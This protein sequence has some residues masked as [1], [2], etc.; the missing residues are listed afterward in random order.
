MGI[1]QVNKYGAITET[2]GL[3][4]LPNLPNTSFMKPMYLKMKDS[5]L[6]EPYRQHIWTYACINAKATA[7]K[8]VPFIIV[9][10]DKSGKTASKS[11]LNKIR[12]VPVER[13]HKHGI[14]YLV[15][16]GFEVIED[17]D[18][19]NLFNDP[20]PLM[21][22]AQLWE[23]YIV[24][25]HMTGEVFWT[26]GG[27]NGKVNETELPREIGPYPKQAFEP[28]VDK[29]TG[30]LTGWKKR[31]LGSKQTEEYERHQI[32]RFYRYNPY[33]VRGLAP[34][35]VVEK[36]ASQDLKAMVLNEALFDNGG[37]P[38]GFLKVLE[39]LGKDQKDKLI[40][41]FE[42]RHKGPENSG[43][44]GLL[45][46][47]AEF[48]FNP[49][50]Q[51]DMQYTDGRK[52]NRDETH[53]GLGVPKIKNSI[54]EDINFA[55]ALQ[56]D[57][58]FWQDQ[59]IPEA[60][61]IEDVVNQKLFNGRIKETQ[62]LYCLFDFS[63]VGALQSN[64][65]QNSD[66]AKRY[67][68]MG[69][70][71]NAINE[72]L[73][74]GFDKTEW[75]DTGYLPMN[76]VPA[77]QAG[78]PIETPENDESKSEIRHMVTKSARKE[79][80]TRLW[81]ARVF[82]PIE[83]A[84]QSKIKKYWYDL[85]V[86]QLKLFDDATKSLVKAI[87]TYAELDAILF[88]NE[89]WKAKL[90]QIAYPYLQNSA[91]YSIEDIT[92]LLGV[93]VWNVTDPRILAILNRKA[94]KIVGITDRCWSSLKNNL[95]AG[96]REGETVTE[97]STRIRNE[98]NQR[99]TPARTLTIAR[100]E[101]AQIASPVRHTVL[102]GEGVKTSDWSSSG[103][104]HVRG[105]HEILDGVGPV[106]IDHNY[107]VNLNRMAETLMYPSDPAGPAD[108]VINCRCAEIPAE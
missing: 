96:I 106:K 9:R 75:G 70:S 25:M 87:P 12:S 23:S 72:R 19:Y 3:E 20:N 107:M 5:E 53:A 64:V 74:L 37:M 34:F 15:K 71:A 27:K 40:N 22:R 2:K 18:V 81:I 95:A 86:E 16:S 48:I 54:Y 84:F 88:N 103:D 68:D 41:G 91:K 82:T 6:T 26:L 29:E 28:I 65:M 76:L 43:K 44:V 102:V 99:A 46:G 100:T 42:A 7:L 21:C 66:V 39:F 90:K 62:G 31:K 97:L 35:D 8:G 56:A 83:A 92:E 93:E 101:T 55:T 33:Q 78:M 30:N 49:N 69:Y 60:R 67:F 14:E 24:L 58:S 73:N 108:Q 77:D 11:L 79:K 13:M 61:Y 80:I 51:Q 59:I 98:F 47:G 38:G 17:G 105:D 94:N 1:I 45:Q 4:S 36:S 50:S 85:R 32:I 89:E 52:W 57:K 63:N 10:Y 104:E